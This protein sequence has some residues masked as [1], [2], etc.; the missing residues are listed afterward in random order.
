MSFSALLDRTVD[1][2]TRTATSTDARGNDVYTE[3]TTSGVRCRR[4]VSS[5][6]EDV[7]D[8]QRETTRYLYFFE[9]D[10][11]IEAT[12]R[13]VDDGVTLEVDGPVDEV[14]G[15]RGTHHLEVRAFVIEGG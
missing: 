5:T 6:D 1:L 11:T 3:A 2:V 7:A 12:T 8:A 13:I 14:G 15:R 10:V 4:D 9:A